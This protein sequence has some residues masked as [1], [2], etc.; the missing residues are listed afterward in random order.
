MERIPM[1]WTEVFC[2]VDDF[3]QHFE[4]LWRARQIEGRER[5]RKRQSRLASSEIMTILIMFHASNYRTFKHFYLMLQSRHRVDFPK[6][7]SYRRFVELMPSM[8]A[9]LSAYLQ[10]RFGES[11]GVAFIDS[12]A[13]AVCKNKRINRNRVFAGIARRGKT[14]MGWFYGFKLH[15]IIND[16]GELLAVR[17]TPGNVDDRQPVTELVKNLI[18][19]LFGD[20]GYISAKLFREL[21]EQGVQLVTQIRKNMKNRLMPLWDKIMLRKRSLIETVNDQLKNIAQTQHSRHRSATN[22]VVNLMAGLIS[23]THQPKKP[24]LRMSDA[25][26]NML[27]QLIL[28]AP[29]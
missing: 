24:S 8:L 11:I 10:T 25:D 13:L 17:L 19:K 21:W 29:A 7:V 2:D 23:Y 26:Q 22:F 14:T 6:L 20:K 16:R 5:K 28:P 4:P 18:G 1:D 27:S 9:L 3:C 15:L 12:T